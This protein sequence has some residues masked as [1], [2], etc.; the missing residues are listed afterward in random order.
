MTAVIRLTL[1]SY[2]AL[3]TDL[4][5]A[6]LPEV[7]AAISEGDVR[8]IVRLVGTATTKPIFFIDGV[9]DANLPER[10]RSDRVA[11]TVEPSTMMRG[12]YYIVEKRAGHWQITED[13]VQKK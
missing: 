6:K 3:S 13:H 1:L 4:S 11:V 8:E 5:E 2:A 10:T 7:R 12:Y 9:N